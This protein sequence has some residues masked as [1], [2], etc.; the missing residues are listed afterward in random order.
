MQIKELWV[1][2]GPED[3]EPGELEPVD[4]N[5]PVIPPDQS[6]P[7]PPSSRPSVPGG[8]PPKKDPKD[9]VT[10]VTRLMCA[11]AYLQAPFADNVAGTLL[12][13]ESAALTPSWGV[14]LVTLIRNVV[15]SRRRRLAR[16]MQLGFIFW[17]AVL[18]ILAV[19]SAVPTATVTLISAGEL[20]PAIVV[21]AYVLGF[22]AVYLHYRMIRI[23][24]LEVMDGSKHPGDYGT[25]IGDEDEDRLRELN[26][27]NVVVYPG[28][29]PFA[30]FG[31]TLDSWNIAID[32]EPETTGAPGRRQVEDFKPIDVHR[33]LLEDM[34]E[35]VPDLWTGDILFALGATADKIKKPDDH[36]A[37]VPEVH[38]W[39]DWP[40]SRVPQEVVERYVHKPE[41][42]NRTYAV[43]A[44]TAWRGEVVIFGLVRS[45]RVGRKVFIEGRTHAL[46]PLRGSYRDN[47]YVAQPGTSRVYTSVFISAIKNTHWLL[48]GGAY[49]RIRRRANILR[50][51]RE[52]RRLA[53]R[54]NRGIP[55]NYG[56][57]QSIREQAQAPEGM[58]YNA[59]V[60][61]IMFYRVL[62]RQIMSSLDMF[63]SRHCADLTEF[64][65]QANEILNRTD[66]LLNR[67]DEVR[68]GPD[69]TILLTEKT[70]QLQ[71][72]L[73]GPGNPGL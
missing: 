18:L 54:L 41:E 30:G 47:K 61:E 51:K 36:T 67:G 43:M 46:L 57:G 72:G 53:R 28:Y 69:K 60:D 17:G 56:G 38:Q 1:Q 37:I 31:Y 63:L 64:R 40:A 25:K 7:A 4:P 29:H 59:A 48:P 50:W 68:F 71:G 66:I 70:T 19:L 3:V 58:K 45:E 23:S 34:A 5:N 6:P 44:R 10:A 39:T 35:R 11:T 16:D 33:H 12:D 13:P 32:L 21:V 2:P 65:R 42:N 26:N 55:R 8:L 14:D 24:V 62:T 27:A 52:M 49:R 73:G 20:V 9:E 15:K 22:I